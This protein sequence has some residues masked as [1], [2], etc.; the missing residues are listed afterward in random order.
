MYSF[1]FSV[2]EEAAAFISVLE[3]YPESDTLYIGLFLVDEYYKRKHIGIRIITGIKA[4]AREAHC[5]KIK[6]SV[7]EKNNSAFLF[8]KSS[9]FK[10]T[11]DIDGNFSKECSLNKKSN[12]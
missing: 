8:W 12:E 11:D 2:Q 1:G 3:G 6:L 7:L 10:V 5:Q 4:A 9:G